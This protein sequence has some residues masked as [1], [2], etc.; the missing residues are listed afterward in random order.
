MFQKSWKCKLTQNFNRSQTFLCHVIIVTLIIAHNNDI[1]TFDDNRATTKPIELASFMNGNLC[2]SCVLQNYAQQDLNVRAHQKNKILCNSNDG[3]K[4]LETF[5][6]KFS[7]QKH[8][9]NNIVKTMNNLDEQ[10]RKY[11]Q[12]RCYRLWKQEWIWGWILINTIS[13]SLQLFPVIVN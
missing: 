2:S 13:I 6:P 8:T 3:Q 9:R 7:F 12:Q 11:H 4:R 1:T 10:T 5:F